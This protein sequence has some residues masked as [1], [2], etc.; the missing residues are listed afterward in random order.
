MSYIYAVF[1]GLLRQMKNPFPVMS[2]LFYESVALW[3]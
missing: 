1:I 3:I 2:Y